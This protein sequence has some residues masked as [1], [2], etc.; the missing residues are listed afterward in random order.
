MQ[1]TKTIPHQI[2]KSTP[3]RFQ[4]NLLPHLPKPI[5]KVCWRIFTKTEREEEYPDVEQ[6]F[7]LAKE[8]IPWPPSQHT[9]ISDPKKSSSPV[10]FATSQPSKNALLTKRWRGKARMRRRC[11]K[12]WSWGGFEVLA[13]CTC[14]NSALMVITTGNEIS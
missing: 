8:K 6:K 4:L 9:K 13:I 1:W 14:V 5:C 12:L 3:Q 2:N 7:D 10:K 11:I